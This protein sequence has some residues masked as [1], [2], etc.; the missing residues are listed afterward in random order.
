MIYREGVCCIG[1][2]PDRTQIVLTKRRDLSIWCLPGGGIEPGEKLEQAASRELT[3][4]TG[5][6][7]STLT[8]QGIYDIKIPRFH[9]I[10]WDR[11]YTYV[12]TIAGGKPRINDEVKKIEMFEVNNLPKGFLFYQKARV[13]DAI[14]KTIHSSPVIQQVRVRD[15]LETLIQNFQILKHPV[16][17]YRNLTIASTRRED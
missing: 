15:V 2:T 3:E 10:F 11:V 4:E 13:Q 7:T 16:R 1:F 12:G 17:L 6:Y 8:Y 5:F 9:P 14:N